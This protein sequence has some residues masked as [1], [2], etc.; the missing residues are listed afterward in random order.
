MTTTPIQPT[1]QQ[2]AP[3]DLRV[4]LRALSQEIRKQINCVRIGIIQ[5]F[6]A[7]NQTATVQ[8]AQQ[9]VTSIQPDGARTIAPFAPLVSVPVFFPCGGG[10]TLTFPIQNGDECI[11]LFN[12][13]ELDNWL[14]AGGSPAPTTPRLHDLADGIAI[15]GVRS[16]PRSLGSVSTDSAQLRSDDGSTFVDIKEN[17]VSITSPQQI[18]LNT[19]I[20]R[21][22]GGVISIG[23]P[24]YIIT[25]GLNE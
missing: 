1:F 9:Q 17:N 20:V 2:P 16:F 19:P 24:P 23:T 25:G 12:D 4:L 22:P 18:T 6:N 14:E 8:I 5:S 7:G 3:P 15:V 13:R 10:Y 21:I 11:V